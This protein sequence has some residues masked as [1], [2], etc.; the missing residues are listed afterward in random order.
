[1]D[2]ETRR[3]KALLGAHSALLPS[4]ARARVLAPVR[5]AHARLEAHPSRAARGSYQAALRF[6]ISAARASRADVLNQERR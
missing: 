6:A 2:I 1:M 5:A 3:L 4:E